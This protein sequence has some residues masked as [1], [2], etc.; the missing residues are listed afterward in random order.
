MSNPEFLMPKGKQGRPRK[1][2][3]GEDRVCTFVMTPTI[4]Q[5][6]LVIANGIPGCDVS[7]LAEFGARGDGKTIGVLG[8][9]C[10]H[11]TVHQE[12]GYALPTKWLGVTDKFT[13]HKVKT[14]E[15]LEKPLWK[16]MW[17]GSD[18]GHVWTAVVNGRPVV[19]LHLLGIEDQGALDRVRTECHGVWFEEPAPTSVMVDSSGV[20]AE[21]WATA[22]TSMRLPTH[23]HVAVMTLNYPDEDH[24]TWQRF[25]PPTYPVTPE[26]AMDRR[27]GVHPTEPSRM[28]F[29]IPVGERA[30]AN[31]RAAWATA[32]RDRPDLLR[33]LIQGLPG[34]LMIGKQVAD[35]FN[36]DAH[37]AKERIYPIE[38]EPLQIG[39]DFG[40]TPTAIIGQFWRGQRRVYAGLACEKGGVKQH[41]E[42]VVRPW[43]SKYAPWAL[44]SANMIAG[45]YDIAGQTGEQSDIER[46]PISELEK[47]LPGLWFPGPI[48]WE[49]RKH[50]LI[51]AMNH[52]IAAGKPSLQIDPQDGAALIKALSGRWH[53]AV[54]RQ[55]HVSRDLPKKPNHPWEDLGDSFIYWLWGLT[56]ETQPPSMRVESIFDQSQLQQFGGRM[57]VETIF[58]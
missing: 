18:G 54:D 1:H 48:D 16:G 38:G 55:G 32:L 27:F 39:F 57:K 23:A 51:S 4:Q 40:H 5:A 50:V 34:S 46:D 2:L 41:C 24:W 37:V 42:N 11:A 52:H 17:R 20:T 22:I 28:W 44:R 56:S 43:I 35:G 47:Q 49:S 19:E 31:Q 30:D 33:R 10:M 58:D 15:S 45:C 12:K 53:Y 26:T 8:G 13:S 36:E 7:E 21:A 9:F 14:F 29:R 25:L 6:N 3:P